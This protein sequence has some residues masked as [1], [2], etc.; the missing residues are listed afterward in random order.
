M[1]QDQQRDDGQAYTTLLQE[2]TSGLHYLQRAA[3]GPARARLLLLHGV[4]G[5][6]TNLIA[7]ANQI[8][9]RVEVQLLR[10]P[11]SFGPGQH[12][13][14]PVSFTGSGP[15]IDEALA[16]RSRRALIDFVRAQSPTLPTVIAGFSQGGI[17]SASVGLSAPDVVSGFSIL[18]GRILPEL[19]PH[20]ASSAALANVQGFIGHGRF[21]DKLP[22]A[23][24]ERAQ[25][26]LEELGV[27]HLT[28]IYS[29]GHTLPAEEVADF[30]QWLTAPL[31]LD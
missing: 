3:A 17:M 6:E 14:F 5:N 15:Q 7:V 12:A 31:M 18:S 23:W 13:W 19:A 29:C 11:L 8:D 27:K 28:K 22:L 20:I 24:A 30:K 10:A 9:P 1:H 21:D 16:E 4:G 2:A 26:W 25:A